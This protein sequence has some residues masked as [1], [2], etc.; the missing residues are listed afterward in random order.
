MHQGEF[1]GDVAL[2]GE[3]RAAVMRAPVLDAGVSIVQ[4]HLRRRFMVQPESGVAADEMDVGTVVGA[5]EAG[6]SLGAGGIRLALSARNAQRAQ[7]AVAAVDPVFAIAGDGGSIEVEHLLHVVTGEY[8]IALLC[9]RPAVDLL[10]GFQR[11][12]L[13]CRVGVEVQ[14][15]RL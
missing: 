3:M 1:D 7:T 9:Q 11:G 10:Q 5:D 13:G 4:H 14:V 15:D 2:Q 8:G 6:D 12:T